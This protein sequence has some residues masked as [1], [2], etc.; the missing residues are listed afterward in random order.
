MSESTTLEVHSVAEID[1]FTVTEGAI[2][3][4]KDTFWPSSMIV[5]EIHRRLLSGIDSYGKKGIIQRS[6][7]EFRKE[8]IKIIREPENFYVRGTDVD[9]VV[10]QYFSALDRILQ[11]LPEKPD[12]MIEGIVKNAAWAYYVFERIHPFLDGNGRTG[13]IILNR[14]LMGAGFERLIFLD[15]WFDQERDNHLN[16]MNLVDRI[17]ILAPLE[18]YL[19][20]S[21][22]S[23]VQNK[24]RL[25]EIDQLI[26]QKEQEIMQSKG[27]RSLAGI[28]SVFTDIGIA[29]P[30][31]VILQAS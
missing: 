15:T 25:L 19:L 23:Q 22:R 28:W 14:V 7:G 20:Y 9:P 31:E 26:T 3:D 10:R 2:G 27:E 17:G 30:Q 12:E 24:S 13:R 8:D 4:W 16:A 11:Q 29:T 18:L 5:P 21:L 1:N 6:P